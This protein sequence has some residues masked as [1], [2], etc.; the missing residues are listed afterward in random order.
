[1]SG[2]P[3]QRVLVVEDEA[4]TAETIALYLRN[5]GLLA[6]VARTGSAA[7]EHL[8]G[9]AYALVILD[10]MLPE[11]DGLTLCREIRESSDVPVI[12]VT[13]LGQEQQKIT[14]LDL[15]ADDYVVKPFSPRELMAR[16]R[17]RL[18]TATPPPRRLVFDQLVMD[19][20]RREV[21][22]HGSTVELTAVEFD[23]LRCLAEQ[24]GRTYTREQLMA[25]VLDDP[26]RRFD[27]TIDAHV[28]NLR[29]K[30]ERDRRRPEFI[31]TVFGVGYRFSGKAR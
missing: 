10:L 11:V 20:D 12:M 15:G 2:N 22:V 14:G 25:A 17:A 30:L 28:K 27:R 8:A 6:D 5:E 18:R 29:R 23:L 3:R 24:P 1:M 9:K 19:L 13:A 7:R 16:V 26:E 21:E 4:A 31:Q